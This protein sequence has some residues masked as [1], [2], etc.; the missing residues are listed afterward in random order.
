MALLSSPETV[1]MAAADRGFSS[2]SGG[3]GGADGTAITGTDV[4]ST[5]LPLNVV[6]T[7]WLFT[8]DD[9]VDGMSWRVANADCS[10]ES[11]L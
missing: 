3:G 4:L 11:L 9:A 5:L 2:N 8:V 7:V 10:S 1:V 6:L